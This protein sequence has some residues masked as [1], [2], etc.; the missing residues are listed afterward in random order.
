LGQ[1]G[2]RG[3]WSLRAALDGRQT[4]QQGD[5]GCG[6]GM[7][8]IRSMYHGGGGVASSAGDGTGSAGRG[9]HGSGGMGLLAL[10]PA[11]A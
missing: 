9:G 2:Q 8:V 10:E 6:A 1:C 7:R 11:L 4:R 5:G 3:A